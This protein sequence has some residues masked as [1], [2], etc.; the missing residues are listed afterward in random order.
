MPH[1]PARKLSEQLQSLSNQCSLP[2][3]FSVPSPVLSL[4]F[5]VIVIVI[6]VVGCCCPFFL[7]PAI[8][9]RTRG[10]GNSW[11]LSGSLWDG[12]HV[13]GEPSPR[14]RGTRRLVAGVP[15]VPGH[16]SALPGAS[17]PGTGSP[18]GGAFPTRHPASAAPSC[19]WQL[20]VK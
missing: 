19:P 18:S 13:L 6:S 8:A 7:T 11:Q 15:P 10:S 16:A 20:V 2:F 17:A 14:P 12:S 3:S 5:S 1:T 4:S 9:L